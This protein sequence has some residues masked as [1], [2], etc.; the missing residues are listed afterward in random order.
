VEIDS[1][2][3]PNCGAPVATAAGRD[4]YTCAYCGA[5]LRL[6]AGASGVPLAVLEELGD[7]AALLADV[8][9]RDY[10]VRENAELRQRILGPQGQQAGT[11]RPWRTTSSPVAM[12]VLIGIGLLFACG[13]GGAL[14]DDAPGLRYAY[15]LL[16]AAAAGI[17]IWKLV[18]HR[19]RP[20]SADQGAWARPARGRAATAELVGLRRQYAANE[21]SIAALNAAIAAAAHEGEA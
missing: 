15:W 4:A 3:C 18:I 10:L 12:A 17:A 6:T 11:I 16:V 21:R 8:A 7:D 9:K 19:G 5:H 2:Q 1:L 13:I 14:P 20:R